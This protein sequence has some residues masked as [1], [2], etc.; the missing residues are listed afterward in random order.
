[1]AHIPP[2]ARWY[3]AE[4]VEQITVEGDPRTVAHKNL[5]LIRADSPEEAYKKSLAIGREGE[6]SYENPAGRLVQIAFRGISD[7]NVI[8]DELDH[9]A[10]LLYEEIVGPSEEE[11]KRWLVPKEQLGV[12]RL[13][14]TGKSPDYSSK[15][16]MED[17]RRISNDSS[18]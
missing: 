3:V 5:V 11:V 12:F 13:V 10:E 4:L 17:V 14:E 9:G 1:M 7:L 8:H 16:I 15:E 6:D 2:S 18:N